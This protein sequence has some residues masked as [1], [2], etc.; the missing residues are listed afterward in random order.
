MN[1][2]MGIDPGIRGGIAIILDDKIVFTCVFNPKMTEDDF[3][4]DVKRAL[5]CLFRY[6]G[7]TIFM[8][9]VGVMPGDG[10]VGAFTFGRVYGFIRGIIK[11]E[12]YFKMYDVSPVMWQTSMS[13]LSGGNK[14]VTKAKAQELFPDFKMTHSIADAILIAGY[15]KQKFGKEP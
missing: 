1:A 13:C 8:E 5:S 3:V 11:T 14:N 7:S 10:R 6:G 4:G 12:P 9:K 15:A 2:Y